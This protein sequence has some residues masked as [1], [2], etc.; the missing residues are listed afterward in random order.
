MESLRGQARRPRNPG[1]EGIPTPEPATGTSQPGTPGRR[2]PPTGRPLPKH[3][4]FWATWRFPRSTRTTYGIYQL[5]DKLNKL[6]KW[7]ITKPMENTEIVTLVRTIP[8]KQT[9][10]RKNAGAFRQ[11]NAFQPPQDPRGPPT[12]SKSC[13][14]T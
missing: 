7:K 11:P 10:I 3:G 6:K 9:N 12:E 8:K 14:T 2:G 1:A 5:Q 4:G 13:K